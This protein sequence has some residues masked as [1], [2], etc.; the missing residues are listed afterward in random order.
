MN[1]K[2]KPIDTSPANDWKADDAWKR[3]PAKSKR[4][5]NPT[6]ASEPDAPDDS[7]WDSLLRDY[8]F[9]HK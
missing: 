5:E 3:K 1:R 6:P 7:Y 2:I 8:D 4:K 9:K